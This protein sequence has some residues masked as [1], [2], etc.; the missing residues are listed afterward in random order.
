M[1]EWVRRAVRQEMDRG[2]YWL[3]TFCCGAA[4]ML[5]VAVVEAGLGVVWKVLDAS[6]FAF[7]GGV[8][9][10]A[11]TAG[12]LSVLAAVQAWMTSM[13]LRHAGMPAWGGL[14][15]LVPKAGLFVLLVALFVHGRTERDGTWLGTLGEVMGDKKRVAKLL[16]AG[17]VLVGAGLAFSMSVVM[18]GS[19]DVVLF[20][21]LPVGVG[22]I[23][24]YCATFTGHQTLWECCKF[25]F[26][27]LA[28][29]CACFLAIGAEGLICILMALPLAAVPVFLGAALAYA[30]QIYPSPKSTKPPVLFSAAM[31]LPLVVFV[32]GEAGNAAPQLSSVTTS[33]VIDAPPS[34]VWR[35]IVSFNELAPPDELMF[36]AGIAY[37]IRAEI[38]GTGVGAVRHC[39]FSTGPFVE[40]ITAWD[41]PRLLAFDVTQNPPTMD[42]MSPYEIKPRHI[43]GHFVSERGQFLLVDLGDGR[44]R[45]EGTTWYKQ[46]FGP[47]AYWRLWSD[48]I[49]HTIHG[50]VL[51]H[52]K[53]NAE[54]AR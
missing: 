17:L 54:R 39:V 31:F 18:Y 24:A 4:A 44:T 48:H 40:P 50:R 41:E 42:E 53:G 11:S 15:V 34:V 16:G 13:R 7:F 29:A 43:E 30:L 36:R 37:P 45:V 38:E 25:S 14:A 47:D 12:A 21:L 26:V 28:I 51:R 32:N 19:Y 2:A 46:S 27:M 49:I 52:I 10:E 1:G 20:L 5:W 22:F 6:V 9:F 35:N 3:G 33:L 8:G 23:P